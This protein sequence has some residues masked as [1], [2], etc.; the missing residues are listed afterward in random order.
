MKIDFEAMEDALLKL[1]AR[2]ETEPLES[3]RHPFQ[4]E[5]PEW[6]GADF[7]IVKRAPKGSKEWLDDDEVLVTPHAELIT[8]LL[9]ELKDIFRPCLDNGNKYP[10]YQGLGVAAG[11]WRDRDSEEGTAPRDILKEMLGQAFAF[12]GVLREGGELRAWACWR[13]LPALKN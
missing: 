2:I 7:R 9:L 11:I 4:K 8:W 13:R 10:F 1:G 6:R 12:H 3:L 5:M